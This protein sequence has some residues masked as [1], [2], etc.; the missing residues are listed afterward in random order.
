MRAPADTPER[1]LDARVAAA[2]LTLLD[3]ADEIADSIS[4]ALLEKD[5]EVYERAGPEFKADV[6]ASTREHIRRGIEAMAGLEGA[7]HVTAQLWRETGRRRARQ[8]IAMELVLNAYTLGTRVLWEALLA[9][10]E[11][12]RLDDQVLLVA[13]QRV[14][15][16]LDVQNAVFID[17]YRRESVRLQ[18][19]DLQRQQSTLDALVEGRGTDPAFAAEA[20]EVLGIGAEMQVACVVAPYDGSLDEPLTP[21]GERLGRHGIVSHWHVRGGVSFGLLAG[22]LPDVEELVRLLQPHAIGRV[23]VATSHDGVTGFATA[24]QLASRAAETVPRDERRAVAVSQ[25]LP[26]VL[27]AASPEVTALLVHETLAPILA[28][29]PH[30]AEVL[31]QTLSALLEHNGSAKHAAESLFCHRNTVIYRARQIEELTGRSLGDARDRMLLGL[32]LLARHQ[33]TAS[34]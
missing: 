13:G 8:G 28:Q 11:R 9:Q 10:G 26:E 18:R 4:L 20:R 24:F 22:E 30:V 16:A 5:A 7:T 14:W 3:Q 23:G 31:V 15:S 21:P 29:P 32:G 25:R 6:R 19:R 34:S 1:D 17:A 27:L 33:V 2:W 12:G